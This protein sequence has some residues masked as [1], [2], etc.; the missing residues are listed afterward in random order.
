MLLWSRGNL[1]QFVNEIVHKCQIINKSLGRIQ[2]CSIQLLFTLTFNSCL[3]C[4]HTTVS[5]AL[6]SHRRLNCIRSLF[7]DGRS[8]PLEETVR[9]F[10]CLSL[11]VA[12]MKLVSVSAQP[13]WHSWEH[14]RKQSRFWN[15]LKGTTQRT[16]RTVGQKHI[17]N[18][19][20]AKSAPLIGVIDRWLPPAPPPQPL[21]FN[22]C[23]TLLPPSHWPVVISEGENAFHGTLGLHVDP[24]F[25]SCCV[26]I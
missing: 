11:C 26:K 22:E 20:R 2:A 7:A 8:S 25:S 23:R 4:S 21:P 10:P 15:P 16:A 17:H 1:A 6:L 14:C 12:C 5:G 3:L 13:A 18:N 19:W 9:L 24:W